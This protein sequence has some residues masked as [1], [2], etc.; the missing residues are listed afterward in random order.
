MSQ[1][2]VPKHVTN[3]LPRSSIDPKT[4]CT[5]IINGSLYLLLIFGAHYRGIRISWMFSQIITL[6]KSITMFYG[7]QI[8]YEIFHH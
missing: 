6:F 4:M 1:I 2:C 5:T 8:L 7:A 3:I